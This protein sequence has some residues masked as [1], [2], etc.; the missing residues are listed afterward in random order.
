MSG[1]YTEQHLCV[2]SFQVVDSTLRAL[3][4]YRV[5]APG[6]GLIHFSPAAGGR[7]LWRG[8]AGLQINKVN[9]CGG[10]AVRGVQPG[11]FG[12]NEENS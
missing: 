7:E 6:V 4:C 11:I 1:E 10:H 3:A 9:R 5:V 8:S 12:C 2:Y